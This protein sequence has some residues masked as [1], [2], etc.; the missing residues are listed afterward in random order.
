MSALPPSPWSAC[1]ERG[2]DWLSS[3]GPDSDVVISS[4]VRL[5]RNLAGLPFVNRATTDDRAAVLSRC[6]TQLVQ[7]GLAPRL[8]WADVQALSPLD[9]Q[10]LVER[11]LMSKE[12]AKGD[13]PR[14]LAVSTPDQ[15]LSIMMNEEDHLRLQVL[16]PACAL[17]E[18]W[19]LADELDD[20][21]ERG[22]DFAFHHR[23]GY[24]TACPTNVGLGARMSVMLHLPALKLT[25][26]VDKVRRAAKDMALT[27]RGFYGEGSEATGDLYQLSNQTTLGK[28]ERVT[29]DELARQ[30]LPQVVAYERDARQRLV[31]KRRRVIDDAVFRAFGTLRSARLL[32]P[33][34]ALSLLSLVRLGVLAGLVPSLR[35]QTVNQLM[36]LTQPS[37]LQRLVGSELDQ[38]R[39]R[40]ARADLMRERLGA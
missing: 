9:R 25:G 18:A 32:T 7:S 29:L 22:L 19:R 13:Q 23:F 31:E 35:E 17:D 24:L 40:E 34:E 1:V 38:Q 14:A 37:H 5:A 30:I 11:H 28:S 12:H 39:R 2:A 21:L 26:E 20:V 33:E 15:R 10:L 6:R 27:V 36:L 4:R 16:L 3:A 8:V